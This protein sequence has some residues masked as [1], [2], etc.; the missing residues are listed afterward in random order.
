MSKG[1]SE[2]L[3]VLSTILLWIGSAYFCGSL[4][5]LMELREGM[6]SDAFPRIMLVSVMSPALA[7]CASGIWF[8][9]WNTLIEKYYGGDCKLKKN[10]KVYKFK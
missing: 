5:M 9:I 1:T 2:V 10:K 6:E 8:G 3:L 4:F 7:A